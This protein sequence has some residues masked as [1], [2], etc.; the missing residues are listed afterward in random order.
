MQRLVERADVVAVCGP[1]AVDQWCDD[2][3]DGVAEAEVVDDALDAASDRAGLLLE[4]WSVENVV[5]LVARDRAVK[6]AIAEV[7]AGLMG[8]RRPEF[9]SDQGRFLSDAYLTRGEETLKKVAKGAERSAAQT[10][11]GPPAASTSGASWVVTDGREPFARPSKAFP[12][13]RGGF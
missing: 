13:G 2:D 1:R 11:V 6:R 4:G 5:E 3:G 12:T 8:R 7:A 10:T 9:A